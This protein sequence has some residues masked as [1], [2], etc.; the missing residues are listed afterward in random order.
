[1]L[2]YLFDNESQGLSLSICQAQNLLGYGEQYPPG[3][4]SV[5]AWFQK[6]HES[7]TKV[8]LIWSSMT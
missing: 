4:V 6:L 5:S 1:M 2:L 7:H 3:I 8:C